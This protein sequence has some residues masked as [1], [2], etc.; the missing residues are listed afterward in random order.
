MS[1][2]QAAWL[3]EPLS[4]NFRRSEFACKCGCG[5]AQPTPLIVELLQEVRNQYEGPIHVSSGCRCEAHNRTVGGGKHSQH[6]TGGA[7]DIWVDC[8]FERLYAI[9]L[10][11]FR[12]HGIGVYLEG[13]KPGRKRSRLHVDDRGYRARWTG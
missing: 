3:A 13:A 4:E 2:N 10:D 5:F 1:T 11:V 9:V 7:A 8:H 6:L 12:D